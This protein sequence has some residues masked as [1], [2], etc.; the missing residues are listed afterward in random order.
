MEYSQYEPHRQRSASDPEQFSAQRERLRSPRFFTETL[1]LCVLSS[2]LSVVG[3]RVGALVVLEL[4]LRAVSTMLSTRKGSQN[5]QLFLL[6][7]YSL[8]CT[9]TSSLSFLQEGVP[10]RTL[11]LLLCA[12]LAGL[13]MWHTQALV[14]RYCGVCIPLLSCWHDIPALLTTALKITFTVAG[15]AAVYLI[16][17]DFLSTSEAVR[18]WTPLTIC[19]TLLVVYM[20]GLL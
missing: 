17:K 12:G 7:Q 14:R 3:A 8:G 19:Y 4:S 10:H 6:C 9:L 15:M 13:L 11:S 5:I 18:F 16:N 20:Q 1:H 2:I